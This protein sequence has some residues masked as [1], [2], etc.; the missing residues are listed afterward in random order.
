MSRLFLG[1]LLVIS[2][3][4]A[5]IE[6]EDYDDAFT[7]AKQQNKAVMIMFSAP[8][9]K[10]CRYMKSTVYTDPFVDSY[11]EEFFIAVEIDYHDNPDPET[12][13]LLGTPN[14]YFLDANHKLIVPQMIGGAKAKHFLE[15]LQAVTKKAGLD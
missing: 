5:E 3:V 8:S 1:L 7:L 14:Y 9:C 12:F 6:W 13:Q 10:V 2:F 15:K 11:L 4:Y